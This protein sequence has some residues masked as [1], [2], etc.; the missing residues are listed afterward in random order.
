M[1]TASTTR[2]INTGQL[3]REVGHPLS[4]ASDGTTTTVTCH[5][6]GHTDTALQAAVDA[7]VAIDEAGNRAT[8]ERR[9][10]A[11]LAANATY[12]ARS[13]PTTAQNTAQLKVVTQECTAIIRLLLNLVETTD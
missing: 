6:P 7:H 2:P 13:A 1:S 4:T 9:A 8:L 11:A 5:T 10:A 12:V 3:S